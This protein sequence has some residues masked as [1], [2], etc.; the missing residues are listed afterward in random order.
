MTIIDNAL[1]ITE[2]LE[3]ANSCLTALRDENAKLKSDIRKIADALLNEATEREWCDEYNEFVSH[4][5]AKLSFPYLERLTNSWV[6]TIVINAN[7]DCA[8]GKESDVADAIARAL[9]DFGDQLN[10]VD[11]EIGSA[12]VTDVDPI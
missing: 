6:A 11:Y 12:D 9:Y 4:V 3:R 2:Q 5:N 8:K 7:F 10:G 1:T